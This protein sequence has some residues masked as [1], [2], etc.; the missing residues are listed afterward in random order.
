MRI[1]S[2]I[3]YLALILTVV[4]LSRVFSIR[5]ATARVVLAEYSPNHNI[6]TVN[7]SDVYS[8]LSPYAFGSFTGLSNQSMAAL[9]QN[10][11]SLI[12]MNFS[13]PLFYLGGCRDYYWK[14]SIGANRSKEPRYQFGF[15]DW[16]NLSLRATGTYP[17][18]CMSIDMN[19]SYLSEFVN[20][21][22][23]KGYKNY[24]WLLNYRNPP[25]K[26]NGTW[27]GLRFRDY[28]KALNN[29][30]NLSCGLTLSMSDTMLDPAGWDRVVLAMAG[31]AS[32][33]LVKSF[34]VPYFWDTDYRFNTQGERSYNVSIGDGTDYS[35]RFSTMA[36]SCP[37]L[38]RLSF[39]VDDMT[40]I[41]NLTVNS[42]R[43]LVTTPKV[44]LSGGKHQ[45]RIVTS[46]DYWNY[47]CVRGLYV[48]G[49]LSI[50]QNGDS[51]DSP[52][53]L[54][55]YH[56]FSYAL[57]GS[58]NKLLEEV[59]SIKQ[60]ENDMKL[61]RPLNLYYG[62]DYY[63]ISADYRG[64]LFNAI[65]LMSLL[66]ADANIAANVRAGLY[67]SDIYASGNTKRATYYMFTSLKN[68]TGYYIVNHSLI[69][70]DTF[71]NV[72][73][74]S[75]APAFKNT[76]YLTV[77]SSKDNSGR[78]YLAVANSNGVN[79]TAKI[80]LLDYN[81]QNTAK[82]YEIWADSL[83]SFSN[84]TK[85]SSRAVFAG[86]SFGYS[87][88]PYSLT[89]FEFGN[90]DADN[91][92]VPDQ[93]DECN[94]NP[95]EEVN[96]WGCSAPRWTKYKN[97][98]T[99]NLSNLREYGNIHNLVIGLPDKG[100]IDFGSKEMNITGYNLDSLIAVSNNYIRVNTITGKN[101]N[102]SAILTLYGLSF[103]SPRIVRNSQDCP[104]EICHIISYTDGTL[105]FN[106]TS[107]STYFAAENPYCGDGS[108]N[109]N[110]TCDSCSTD[111]GG[112]G[113]GYYSNTS[114]SQNNTSSNVGCIPNLNC[115]PWSECVDGIKQMSCVD[116]N[117]CNASSIVREKCE[118]A[119]A[120]ESAK[121]SQV[122]A[123]AAVESSQQPGENVQ[124]QLQ[125]ENPS[126]EPA[127][128]HW[129][130]LTLSVVIALSIAVVSGYF[131]LRKKGHVIRKK[132]AKQP[133]RQS[134]RTSIALRPPLLTTI[135]MHANYGFGPEQTKHSLMTKGYHSHELP[136]VDL[137]YYMRG[138]L[139]KGVAAQTLEQTCLR[140]GWNSLEVRAV[141]Q[142]LVRK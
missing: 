25:S 98:L 33:F 53:D 27:Y 14:K 56:N 43:I 103:R 85:L 37:V 8:F 1:S 117:F 51:V 40:L 57:F 141:M 102:R 83:R 21:S 118:A 5:D 99:T 42:T 35:F 3:I 124:K 41:S 66:S 136:I 4:V 123:M 89:I 112:C 84:E 11:N 54:S 61:S 135:A 17:S 23:S 100:K 131:V 26:E 9:S 130:V 36:L 12:L 45:L 6:I 139:K 80:T 73:L 32:G 74:T 50:F 115:T 119:V 106:V 28:C 22:K 122:P 76:P 91:D 120:P 108:C 82:I 114:T 126:G 92:G 101:L 67:E 69:S 13:N 132:Q 138:E 7:A 68:K 48:Y 109:N 18:V 79:E 127:A 44:S 47:N 111:C 116:L 60:S 133:V 62:V 2:V 24:Y 34:Y 140:S 63:R 29:I 96:R 65:S 71:D 16:V 97:S 31:N 75:N 64:S 86:S 20:Y 30:S 52:I 121:Q 39:L 19:L 15:D 110:E 137:Y 78:L 87:F 55:D 129:S 128:S 58:V 49:K 70:A 46:G 105:V 95:S 125:A 93:L 77:L 88:R 134:T 38:P 104:S 142:Q 59:R 94:S 107:L 81:K 10:A 113:S 90:N 72:Y